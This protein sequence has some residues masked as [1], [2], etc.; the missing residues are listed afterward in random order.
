MT[1][2]QQKL[3]ELREKLYTG[4]A[5]RRN[6]ACDEMWALIAE[7]QNDLDNVELLRSEMMDVLVDLGRFSDWQRCYDSLYNSKDYR[8]R[9]RAL[10]SKAWRCKKASPIDVLCV[11][12]AYEEAIRI[13]KEHNDN[14]RTAE[15][16]M[17]LAKLWLTMSDKRKDALDMFGQCKT[18]AQRSHNHSMEAVT[19]Y[20]MGVLLHEMGYENSSLE[21][22]RTALEM[23]YEQQDKRVAMHI[24]VVRAH[25]LMQKDDTE[26]VKQSLDSWYKHF[27]GEL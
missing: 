17:M 22:L 4:D 25:Y 14:E 7:V 2:R 12:E 6:L 5:M 15:C 23:A 3:V 9:I 1:D 26:S 16:S 27:G 10:G 11:Q 13:S 21:M 19:T 8:L 20:Y 18:Y 24:E